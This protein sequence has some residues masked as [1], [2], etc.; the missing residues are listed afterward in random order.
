MAK[1]ATAKTKTDKKKKGGAPVTVKIK[2]AKKEGKKAGKKEAS[3]NKDEA[4]RSKT[5][6][7]L[8]GLAKL[9]DHP[10]VADLL[11]AGAIAAVA[12]IAEH[13]VHKGERVTSSKMVKSVG[14]AAAAAMGAKLLGDIGAITSAAASAVKKS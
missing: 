6:D 13:Q 1:A 12:A 7:S 3:A 9:A 10:L 14:K 5:R 11:A 2:V 4:K 8:D